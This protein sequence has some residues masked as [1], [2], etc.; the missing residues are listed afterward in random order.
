MLQ[1]HSVL[2]LAQVG[3]EELFG[4]LLWEQNVGLRVLQVLPLPHVLIS[5]MT[6]LC[7]NKG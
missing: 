1:S 6:S 7:R 4:F 3:E 2:C 5:F